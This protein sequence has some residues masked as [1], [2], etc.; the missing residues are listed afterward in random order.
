[1]HYT[2]TTKD[3]SLSEGLEKY[4]QVHIEKLAK[5]LPKFDRDLPLLDIIVRKHKKKSL[6]KAGKKHIDNPVYYD[7]TLKLILP[8][9]PLVVKILGKTI[10][11]A[12]NLGFSHLLKELET[13]KGKHM[14]SDSEYFDRRSIRTRR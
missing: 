1:M 8:K 2:I 10:E 13:Y 5:F 7:G 12:T 11:E 9:K 6:K 4:L 14:S 3:C